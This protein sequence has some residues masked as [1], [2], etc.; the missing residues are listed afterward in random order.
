M[1]AQL[2]IFFVYFLI[3]FL[4]IRDH[5]NQPMTSWG[6]WVALIWILIL[7]SRPISLWFGLGVQVETPDDYLE[8]SPVDRTIFM[9]LE[10]AGLI[11]LLSR[12]IDWDKIF[13]AS[14]WL[15]VFFIYWA[16]SATWSDYSFVSL[17]RWIKDIGNVIMVLL[18][19]TEKNPTA[20]L[21]AVFTR[22]TYVVIPLS[23]LLAKYF[24][25]F[26]R[27]YNPWTWEYTYCG[28]TTNKNALGAIVFVCAL[29]L[30][31]DLLDMRKE[32]DKKVAAIDVAAKGLLLAMSFWLLILSNSSTS[33]MCVLIGTALLVYLNLPSARTQVW[34]LG[35]YA[36]ITISL[37]LLIFVIPNIVENIV[38]MVGRDITLTGR[39]DVWSLSLSLPINPFLG[40]GYQSFW[41]GP[42]AERFWDLFAFKPTQVHNGYLETYLNGGLMGVVLL[43]VMILS[44]GLNLKNG[45]ISGKRY[46]NLLIAF[47]VVTLFYN[48]TEAAFNRMSLVWIVTLLAVLDQPQEPTD[49]AE[50]MLEIV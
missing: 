5:K 10:I 35:T 28:V 12:K 48:L 30:I 9:L 27:Y 33:L 38:G 42:F 6:L 41:L 36:L 24:P 20:A 29:F 15:F 11:A 19:F 13:R 14:L 3:F 2:A 45:F 21:K 39:T 4:F 23:V 49:T 43:L 17:K 26:G 18:I 7:S 32:E 1:L 46:S 22:L 25:E 47:L 34:Y 16:I 31:W 40:T 44:T 8:G 50:E 37:I